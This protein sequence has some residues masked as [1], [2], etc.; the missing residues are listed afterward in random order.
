[1]IVIGAPLHRMQ[2]IRHREKNKKTNARFPLLPFPRIEKRKGKIS[3]RRAMMLMTNK[4]RSKSIKSQ[5]RTKSENLRA[6]LAIFS[7]NVHTIVFHL[8]NV[9]VFTAGQYARATQAAFAITPVEGA[10][11][12]L[13]QQI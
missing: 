11:G 12:D 9:V 7:V 6:S 3:E 8:L 1:M 5:L 13:A 10:A 4:N 2:C